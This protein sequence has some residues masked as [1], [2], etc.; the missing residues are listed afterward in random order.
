[1]KHSLAA[2]GAIIGAGVAAL[3][4]PGILQLIIGMC[5]GCFVGYFIAGLITAR[6]TLL[7]QDFVKLGVLK[8][9]TLKEIVDAVGPYCESQA[10]TITDMDNQPGRLYTWR[11]RRYMIVLLFDM[12]NVC[13]GVTREVL[14]TS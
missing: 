7:Q 1:M 12:N 6:Q 4:E 13:L 2:A 5:A 9:R 11:A 3:I 14:P 10:T 8:G